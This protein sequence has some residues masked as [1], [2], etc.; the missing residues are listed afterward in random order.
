[1][2]REQLEHIIRAAAA[3]TNQYEIVVVGSQSILGAFPDAPATL[4]MSMEADVFPK[5][6][7]D[8]ADLIDGS[9][10]EESAFHEQFGYYAQG[11]GPETAVLPLGWK[12]RLCKIQNANTDLK[13]GL[14]LEPHDLAVSKLI[15][16]RP[17]DWVYVQ[18]MI[19]AHL[20]DTALLVHRLSETAAQAEKIEKAR[21]WLANLL[22]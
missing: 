22:G 13:I 5:D 10:G 21:L 7:P 11:V 9:I 17:K 3:I 12:D 19:D 2:K 14:C 18:A 15:A 20:V 8:L 16:G 6:C 1:M 4:L